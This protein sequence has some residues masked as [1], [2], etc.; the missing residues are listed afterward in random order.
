M[1]QYSPAQEQLVNK[2]EK[3]NFQV[4]HHSQTEDEKFPTIYMSRRNPK[5][6]YSTQYAEIDE[7]GA[8]NGASLEDFIEILG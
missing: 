8:I 2:L 6:R 1:Y 5:A 7:N 3:L 4:N